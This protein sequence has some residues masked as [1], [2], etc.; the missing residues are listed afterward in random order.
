MTSM[1]ASESRL[2]VRS[3]RPECSASPWT[4]SI[5]AH[6][7][8]PASQCRTSSS[9]RRAPPRWSWSMSSFLLV[10]NSVDRYAGGM[11]DWREVGDRSSSAATP[12]TTRTSGRSSATTGSASSTPASRHRQADE[13][14]ADLRELTPLPVGA[15]VNTHVHHD[16]AFGNHRLPAGA[17]LGP[18][19]LRDDDHGRPAPTNGQAW[20]PRIPELADELD[21]VVLDPPDRTSRRRATIVD[22]GGRRIELRYLGRGHTDNDIVVIVPDAD[23]LFAGDLRRGRRAAVLRRRLPARLA[24][25]RRADGRL[26]FTGAVVPGHGDGR[27]P[28]VRESDR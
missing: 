27:R 5:D 23:V 16:H 24:G 28:G 19:P 9:S 17:D 22:A 1:P 10:V 15:V 3:Y 11:S 4:M 6:G 20:R 14:L 21:E 13:I 8:G 12:S 25:D 2:P 26:S 7:S 18:R